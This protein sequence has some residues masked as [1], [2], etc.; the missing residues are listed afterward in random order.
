[1]TDP[2]REATRHERRGIPTFAKV[3]LV[4]GGLFAAA[5]LTIAVVGAIYARKM[6]EEWTT[7]DEFEA[8]FEEMEFVEPD[9]DRGEVAVRMG[10]QDENIH[11]DLSDLGDWL[12]EG[13]ESAVAEGIR[14]GVSFE[15][16]AD[17][18]G[19]FLRVRN[20][21]GRTVVELRGGDDGGE[22]KV[23]GP[24]R[25][26]LGVGDDAAELPDWVPVHPDARV[27]KHLFSGDSPKG[28]FGVVAFKADEGAKGVYDWYVDNLP[29]AGLGV[30][31]S[32][33]R[34]DHDRQ[35]GRIHARSDGLTRERDL[36]L[37]VSG[38]GD[39]GS[40]F[41]VMHKVEH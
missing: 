26:R 16:R 25:V 19:G 18:S 36:F 29:G 33:A 3:I 12:E 39:G 14:E 23:S 17:E 13:I 37:A 30:S 7:E 34:W 31:P 20:R 2:Y 32:N 38:N 1:M 11:F 4:T 40:S 5:L 35:R 28:T 22:L 9:W 27:H 21:D 8:V 24:R 15:G 41:I 10:N 6:A